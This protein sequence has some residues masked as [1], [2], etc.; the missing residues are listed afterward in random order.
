MCVWGG[1]AS[2][3]RLLVGRVA[4]KMSFSNPRISDSFHQA[5]CP[6]CGSDLILSSIDLRFIYWGALG[7]R[8]WKC[9]GGFGDYS[10]HPGYP[11]GWAQEAECKR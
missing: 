2:V 5:Q 8:L 4:T 11:G 1:V 9:S 3:I 10:Q 7:F 6:S